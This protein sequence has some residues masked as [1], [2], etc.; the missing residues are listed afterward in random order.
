MSD[1]KCNELKEKKDQKREKKFRIFG[2]G[3]TVKMSA[4]RF[5]NGRINI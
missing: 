2:V 4:F 3:S 5:T 1:E